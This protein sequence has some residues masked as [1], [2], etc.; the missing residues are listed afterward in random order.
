MWRNSCIHDTYEPGSTFKIITTAAA[1]EEKAV[2][3]EQRFYCP[4]YIMVE[5][6]RIR[7][8]KYGGHG[9]ISFVEGMQGSCNPTFISLGLTLGVDRYYSYFTKFGLLEKT[10]IELKPEMIML[11]PELCPEDK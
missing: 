3:L 1:L 10:G 4:G 2:S 8:H 9:S 11:P 7:C 5:D 6:R